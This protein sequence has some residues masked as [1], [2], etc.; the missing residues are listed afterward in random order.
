[1]ENLEIMKQAVNKAK[2]EYKNAIQHKIS[3]IIFNGLSCINI[4]NDSYYV[5]MKTEDELL[6]A[7][8]E[9]VTKNDQLF[10]SVEAVVKA[11]ADTIW[12][13]LYSIDEWNEVKFHLYCNNSIS[14]DIT[15]DGMEFYFEI[16]NRYNK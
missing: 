4:E 10:E 1:M 3:E 5:E 7:T 12:S 9:E 11:V 8:D 6:N 13:A 16:S 14:Y 2:E 15:V